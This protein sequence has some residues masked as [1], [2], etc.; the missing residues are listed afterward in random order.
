[1][2]SDK[3]L[4]EFLQAR[5]KVTTP[6]QAGLNHSG[7][8]RT[9]GLRREEV[10][11]LAGVSLDYYTRLE[12]GRE[13]HPSDQV[14]AALAGAL[15]LDADATDYLQKLAHPG[16]RQPGSADRPEQVSPPLQWMLRGWNHAPAFVLDRRLDVLASN[17]LADALYGGLTYMDNCLRMIFL[18]PEAKHVYTDWEHAAIAKTAQLRSAVAAD[19]DDPRLH[20]L[21]EEISSHSDDFRRLWERQD[22]RTRVTEDKRFRHPEVGELTLTLQPLTVNGTSG[23]QLFFMSAAPGSPSEQALARL[24]RSVEGEPSGRPQHA[25]LGRSRL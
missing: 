1:M 5:R 12:Q 20:R 2:G 10:A 15:H 6:Q 11:W 13:R 25:R 18:S 8:R 22:V 7:P 23:Q 9:P 3:L 16:V 4:A 17:P 19:P 24:A 21:V 14:L